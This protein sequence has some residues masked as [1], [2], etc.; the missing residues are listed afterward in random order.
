MI[1]LTKT[2]KEYL[3]LHRPI[4]D[5][6]RYRE[7]SEKRWESYK[8]DSEY[9]SAIEWPKALFEAISVFEKKEQYDNKGII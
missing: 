4:A 9:S 3:R 7:L 5:M 8:F 2:D 6:V 1:Y